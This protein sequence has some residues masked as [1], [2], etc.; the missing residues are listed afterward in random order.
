MI[1]G[2]IKAPMR[3]PR[4]RLRSLLIAVAVVAIGMGALALWRRS[5]S[6]KRQAMHHAL[7]GIVL[8]AEAGS[9]PDAAR[10]HRRA[11]WHYQMS[12]KYLAASSRPWL[13]VEPDPPE[14]R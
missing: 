5:V 7:R 14:P 12:R 3:P 4:F 1:V 8:E 9:G 10:W 2:E 6:L 13:P 11:D